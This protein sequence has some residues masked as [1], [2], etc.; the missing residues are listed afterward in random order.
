MKWGLIYYS[1]MV[2]QYVKTVIIFFK[3]ISTLKVDYAEV[4]GAE[5]LS[6]VGFYPLHFCMTLG[7]PLD[8]I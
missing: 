5:T 2:C 8:F 6:T 4:E 1:I 7:G 3:N